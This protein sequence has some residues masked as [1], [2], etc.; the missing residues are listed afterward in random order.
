MKNEVKQ[1]WG[2]VEKRLWV[3]FSKGTQLP[4]LHSLSQAAVLQGL[5][6]LLEMNGSPRPS[7]GTAANEPDPQL[8]GEVFAFA[9]GSISVP[10]SLPHERL[11]MQLGHMPYAF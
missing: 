2:K 4:S 9:V 8:G 3:G 11:I 7:Q 10:L 5:A 1:G 6:D